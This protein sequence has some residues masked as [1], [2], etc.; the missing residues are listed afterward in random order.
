MKYKITSR[1]VSVTSGV[2]GKDL[3]E[4]RREEGREGRR[5]R[6]KDASVRQQPAC[7]WFLSNFLRALCLFHQNNHQPLP[8]SLPP[9]LPPLQVIYADIE[10]VNYVFR[11]FG[12]T[13][14]MVLFLRDGAKV[15]IR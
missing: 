13:G 10:R 11:A 9:S 15:E 3:T 6:G 1:R 4:V 14:D 7:L 8:P 12:T 2:G 5:G